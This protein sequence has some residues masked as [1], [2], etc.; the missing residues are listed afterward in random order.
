[1][2]IGWTYAALTYFVLMLVVIRILDTYPSAR[3]EPRGLRRA[4]SASFAIFLAALVWRLA[5]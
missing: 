2:A 4:L 1:M 5:S 3:A